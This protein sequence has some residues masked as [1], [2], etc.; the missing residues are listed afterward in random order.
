MV[1]KAAVVLALLAVL[2][3]LAAWLAF[4]DDLM[5]VSYTHLDIDTV[6]DHQDIAK[7]LIS[8]AHDRGISVVAEGI[9][10]EAELRSIIKLG[11]DY[12]QGYLLGRPQAAPQDVPGDIK[13]LIRSIAEGGRS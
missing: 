8:Y 7:S 1:G 9:E 13:R 4:G 5:P 6:K 2:G 10:T 11:T 12:L 3:G